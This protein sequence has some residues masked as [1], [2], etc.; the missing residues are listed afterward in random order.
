MTE[1]EL[2]FMRNI[3]GYK[4]ERCFR[5]IIDKTIAMLLAIIVMLAS[6]SFPEN[7]GQVEAA[8]GTY[9]D[10][11]DAASK[12][13]SGVD[14]EADAKG[15]VTSIYT[16]LGLAYFA[17]TISSSRTYTDVTVTL[18]ADIDLS[19]AGV[20]GYDKKGLTNSWTSIGTSSSACFNGTFDG[21]DKTIT[22]VYI[23]QSASFAG[24]F[25]YLSTSAIVKDLTVAD[26]YIT[27]SGDYSNTGAI[28][29]LS[30]G[31]KISNC[32]VNSGTIS[33][34]KNVGGVVGCNNGGTVE[35][36]SNYA[37]VS[38]TQSSTQ[39]GGII[40]VSS[41]GTVESCSNLGDVSGTNYV[42]GIVGYS[43]SGAS[44]KTCYNNATISGYQ[45][46]GGISGRAYQTT[47][48]KSYNVGNL[49]GN[50]RVGGIAGDVA[51]NSEFTASITDC[52]SV[53][54]IS[55]NSNYTGGSTEVGGV[56]GYVTLASVSNC[57]SV[58]SSAG[59]YGKIAYS[60]GTVGNCYYDE[61]ELYTGTGQ[62]YATGLTTAE[63]TGIGTERSSEKMSSFSDSVW[64]FVS[65]DY[66]I[67]TNNPEYLV[68]VF[69][70]PGTEFTTFTYRLN[71]DGTVSEPPV[72]DEADYAKT[73]Y[74]VE[75]YEDGKAF[76]FDT[77]LTGITT[78]T[79][80]WKE[81]IVT[82]IAPTTS[83]TITGWTYGDTASTPIITTDSDGEVSYKY[84]SDDETFTSEVP[85]DA[86][87]Y[88]VRAYTSETSTYQSS[89]SI[90]YE[91]KIAQKA[92]TSD[93]LDVTGTYSYT[94]NEMK[95]TI[96]MSDGTLLAS[97]DYEVTYSDN[98]NASEDTAKVII[99]ATDDGNY[100]GQISETFEIKKANQVITV[101]SVDG[102]KYGEAAF[103]LSIK[104]QKDTSEIVTYSVETNDVITLVDDIVTIIGRGT[105]KITAEVPGDNNYNGA[106]TTYEL[107]ITDGYD[108]T[109]NDTVYT[110]IAYG[111]LLEEPELS[112]L[113]GYYVVAWETAEGV[114]WN[115]DTDVVTQDITL[116]PIWSKEIVYD[117]D[118]QEIL[119]YTEGE[120]VL[121]ASGD[122][123]KFLNLYLDG[124][125]VSTEYYTVT[126]GS[127]IITLHQTFIDSLEAGVYDIKVDYTDGYAWLKLLV[128]E[129]EEASSDN[130]ANTDGESSDNEANTDDTSSDS[131][132][133]TDDTSSDSEVNTDGE[134]SGGAVDTG[135]AANIFY[136]LI[137]MG[138]S[139]IGV[140]Y[141]RKRKHRETTRIEY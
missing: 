20:T 25:G 117:G 29:G 65:D 105:V 5:G 21:N 62:T 129:Q 95:P 84:S 82:P 41:G 80:E 106:T 133:N 77:T 74:T 107:T 114:R 104:G 6:V 59:V 32:T 45:Y 49:Y 113:D 58:S 50:G 26:V 125:V 55:N 122:L 108:V 111:S 19:A 66:P 127:T 23:N 13:V 60:G 22:G 40:G 86:G 57:Y 96:I 70:A 17:S 11:S 12:A 71:E 27:S 92:L 24:L 34:Y 121:T 98:I 1:E 100:Y 8:D 10:W 102:K 119:Q 85:S 7:M 53:T 72:D 51:T 128:E 79:A 3:K 69:E 97:E 135:D 138:V 2:V 15:N 90:S 120:V 56:A 46:V 64:T 139:L 81:I 43:D 124:E 9:S 47:I 134:S 136:L 87:T 48:E 54:T 61:E 4:R 73:G 110:D 39:S 67:L 118:E 63:M 52:Y 130:E 103:T 99:T 35:G 94:G 18:K 44:I 88:Y 14:Y 93:M 78:L 37:T 30:S 76:D 132:A 75:W 115:F 91:F 126:R 38:G 131:E 89:E 33:G 123:D 31:G 28:V 42:G 116:Q 137:L 112:K 36:C 141:G 68:A 101:N 16:A 83:V 109:I 140:A